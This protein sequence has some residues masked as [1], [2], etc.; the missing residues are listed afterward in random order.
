M[1]MNFNGVVLSSPLTWGTVG[2]LHTF[3]TIKSG[4]GEVVVKCDFL[5]YVRVNDDV[6][7]EGEFR[8]NPPKISSYR[9]EGKYFEAKAVENKTLNLKFKKP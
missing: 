3:F 9:I 8:E 7:V 2:T 1:N 5:C 6:L 4:D